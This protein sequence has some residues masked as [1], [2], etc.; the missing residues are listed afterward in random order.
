LAR[1]AGEGAEHPATAIR[2]ATTG[3]IFEI[4]TSGRIVAE[5]DIQ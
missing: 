5:C 3:T 1:S 4:F 2:T